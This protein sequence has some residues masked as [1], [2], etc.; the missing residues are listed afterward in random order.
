MS[1]HI[2]VQAVTGT[3]REA[4]QRAWV[5]SSRSVWICKVVADNQNSEIS[6]ECGESGRRTGLK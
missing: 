1:E 3:A 6:E 2:L 5:S 4:K